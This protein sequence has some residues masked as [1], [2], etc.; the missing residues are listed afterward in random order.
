MPK[1]IIFLLTVS[2]AVVLMFWSCKSQKEVESKKIDLTNQAD[3]ASYAIG[4]Q[5]AE[6]FIQQGLDTVMNIEYIVSGIRDQITKES[7]ITVEDT[8]KIIQSFFEGMQKAKSGDKVSEGEAYLKE[9]GKRSEV[10]TTASGLQYEV[11]E[12]GNGAKPVASST[13]K[14]HYQGTLLNGT[15]F[16]S[17]YERGEPISFP[18]NGVIK[19]WT[20]GLQLM[21]VGSKFKFVIPYD[22]AYGERGAGQLIG[23]FETLIFEVELLDIEK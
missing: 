5:I 8:D 21:P 18:L 3:S 20:E 16:D 6:N 4:V 17:S 14:V 22:L 13:V 19:G 11:I 9:N 10:K 23:P 7:K 2:T 15:V 12:M 1:R